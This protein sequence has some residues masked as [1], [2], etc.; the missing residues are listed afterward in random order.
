MSAAIDALEYMDCLQLESI[1]H[2]KLSGNGK[3]CHI[4]YAKRRKP[5]ADDD[6]IVVPEVI[7]I[8]QPGCAEHY[9]RM[10]GRAEA[11]CRSNGGR[12]WGTEGTEWG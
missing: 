7:R 8:S 1:I 12:M 6:G 3:A 2:W 10:T 4:V 9:A 5:C 11:L